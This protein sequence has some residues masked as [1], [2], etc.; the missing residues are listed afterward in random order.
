M[1]FLTLSRR[2]TERFSDADFAPLLDDEAQRAR[3]LYIEGFIRQIWHRGDVGG[4]CLLVEAEKR[5]DV[6][7]QL[8]SLPL[9]REGM[10]EIV[11]IIPL[12]PY[13]GFGPKQRG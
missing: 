1:Q 5:E 11:A 13:R 8:G 9:V 10:L 6:E 2:V 4:A 12:K 3:T 7:R